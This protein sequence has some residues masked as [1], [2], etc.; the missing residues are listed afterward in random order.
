MNG[1]KT[2]INENVLE[3]EGIKFRKLINVRKFIDETTKKYEM[4]CGQLNRSE[5]LLT[6][7]CEGENVKVYFEIKPERIKPI[8]KT[9]EE[10]K[11]ESKETQQSKS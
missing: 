2:S 10:K 6:K 5:N 7:Q 4:K 3:V 9:A 11:E 8:K 1:I